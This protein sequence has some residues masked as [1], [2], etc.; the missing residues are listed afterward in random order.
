MRRGCCSQ[1]ASSENAFFEDVSKRII[2]SSVSSQISAAD[3]LFLEL[4]T[5]HGGFL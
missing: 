5:L 1:A 3:L 2:T 4:L